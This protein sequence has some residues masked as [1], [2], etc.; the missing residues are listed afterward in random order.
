MASIGTSCTKGWRWRSPRGE[1][2][3]YA[4]VVPDLSV[5]IRSHLCFVSSNAR[6]SSTINLLPE[7]F[8]FAGNLRISAT[9]LKD[10]PVKIYAAIWITR[11]AKVHCHLGQP[12]QPGE[13]GWV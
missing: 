11:P 12:R 6:A 8:H 10:V 9:S 4:E 2:V 5:T 7:S 1:R 13:C 3:A